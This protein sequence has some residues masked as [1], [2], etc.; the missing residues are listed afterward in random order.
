MLGTRIL[1]GPQGLRLHIGAKTARFAAM[2]N[3]SSRP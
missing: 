2:S 3:A 1:C